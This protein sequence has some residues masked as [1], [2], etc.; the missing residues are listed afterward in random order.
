MRLW[1]HQR[2]FT[3][4]GLCLSLSNSLG[5]F[6]KYFTEP[7]LASVLEF[8]AHTSSPPPL[9]AVGSGCRVLNQRQNQFTNIHAPMAGYPQ[10]V[11]LTVP[12]FFLPPPSFLW[13][14]TQLCLTRAIRVSEWFAPHISVYLFLSSSSLRHLTAEDG[15]DG[16]SK[17]CAFQRKREGVTHSEH[18]A[19]IPSH[20]SSLGS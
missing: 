8:T 20:G 5:G 12:S 18:K 9:T 2:S 16:Y 7:S 11:R 14:G 10:G 15:A 13:S 1:F 17:L 4:H 3:S 19:C 6:L